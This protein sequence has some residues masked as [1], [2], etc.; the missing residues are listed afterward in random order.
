MNCNI[1]TVRPQTP[2][3]NVTTAKLSVLCCGTKAPHLR[4]L[5]AL[6]VQNAKHVWME[7]GA[8]LDLTA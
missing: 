6:E 2:I 8:G 7:T 4:N 1:I 3:A 5:L